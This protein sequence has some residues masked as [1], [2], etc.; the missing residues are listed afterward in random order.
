[1]T[2]S[3]R[4][5]LTH[6]LAQSSAWPIFSSYRALDRAQERLSAVTVTWSDAE[7]NLDELSE[8]SAR[9]IEH[10]IA[11]LTRLGYVIQLFVV[12]LTLQ[13]KSAV[14]LHR[15]LWKTAPFVRMPTGVQPG[16]EV[17]IDCGNHVRFAGIMGVP[18]SAVEWMLSVVSLYDIVVPILKKQPINADVIT[19]RE[20]CKAALPPDGC[21]QGPDFEWSSFAAYVAAQNG[22]CMRKT[23][24]PAS[25][26]IE[27]DFFGSADAI[28]SLAEAIA[29]DD[30]ARS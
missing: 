9:G 6:D 10:R 23:D 16:P 18:K 4:T 5:E 22:I 13:P 3:V 29:E 7:H 14:V 30:E 25:G 21:R 24:D 27:I 2:T 15:K 19:A 11:M 8:A 12:S 20:L 26:A 1:M 28:E 17:V